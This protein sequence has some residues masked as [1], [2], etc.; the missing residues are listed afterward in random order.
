GAKSFIGYKN[1]HSNVSENSILTNV[2]TKFIRIYDIAD[3]IGDS[4]LNRAHYDWRK[5]GFTSLLLWMLSLPN[6]NYSRF[7]NNKTPG[8]I[9][10]RRFAF[11]ALADVKTRL[12]TSH[13][14]SFNNIALS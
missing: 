5:N 11:K 14:Y 2:S 8:S 13:Y 4:F 1:S 10:T 7:S 9:R 3:D 12:G 6:T